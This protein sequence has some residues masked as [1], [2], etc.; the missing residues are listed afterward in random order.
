MPWSR[1][2]KSF[3]DEKL[4]FTFFQVIA[5]RSGTFFSTALRR[6]AAR[7]RQFCC[8]I[9]QSKSE[10][11]TARRRFFSL[12]DDEKDEIILSFLGAESSQSPANKRFVVFAFVIMSAS[13]CRWTHTDALLL[14]Y[15]GACLAAVLNQNNLV[16]SACT[17][18]IAE[19]KKTS[20]RTGSE[21]LSPT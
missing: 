11:A 15:F 10:S 9:R 5:Y 17:M 12:Y 21:N 19:R 2:I 14:R 1:L 6:D 18:W 13:D 7:G 16:P 8:E 20:K 4:P 3:S